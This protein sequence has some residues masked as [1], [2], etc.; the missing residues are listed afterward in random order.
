MNYTLVVNS[1]FNDER[2]ESTSE[3]QVESFTIVGNL[4]ENA[5]YSFR[6]MIT[7]T[8]G[9]VSTNYRHFCKSHVRVSSSDKNLGWKR[10][11]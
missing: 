3:V 7:N 10:D 8:V 5:N 11:K 4:S 1:S 9:I 2:V 6:I